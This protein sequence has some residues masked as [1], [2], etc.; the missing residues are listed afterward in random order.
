MTTG[1]PFCCHATCAFIM[2]VA[3]CSAHAFSACVLVQYTDPAPVVVKGRKA[4]QPQATWL[5][6]KQ[7]CMLPATSRGQ[8][9]SSDQACGGSVRPV[10]RAVHLHTYTVCTWYRNQMQTPPPPINAHREANTANSLRM[11]CIA[12]SV[13]Q[14][15]GSR[16]AGRSA[17][18]CSSW[19]SGPWC[20]NSA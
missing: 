9:F 19:S 11:P 15:A 4:R 17:N 20:E 3:L 2:T 5:T 13:L 7:T 16:R 12:V 6:T 1:T 14:C 8:M 18:C 10:L